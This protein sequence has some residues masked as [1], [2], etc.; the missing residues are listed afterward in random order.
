MEYTEFTKRQVQAIAEAYARGRLDTGEPAFMD[1]DDFT[2]NAT[3]GA[4]AFAYASALDVGHEVSLSTAWSV[5][6]SQSGRTVVVDDTEIIE[7]EMATVAQA[8]AIREDSGLCMLSR[9]FAG[10]GT[11]R[12]RLPLGHREHD[13]VS[14]LSGRTVTF[15]TDESDQAL[16][17]RIHYVPA[18]RYSTKVTTTAYP[19]AT[20]EQVSAALPLK[21]EVMSD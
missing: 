14:M 15:T 13:H 4:F 20:D 12:C 1:T 18:S 21:Q 19:V 6:V 2:S 10:V 7:D 16:N 17:D 3:S 11:V 9:T 5:F 8:D